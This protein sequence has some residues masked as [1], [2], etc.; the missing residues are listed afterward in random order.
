MNP[1]IIPDH[2]KKSYLKEM[3]EDDFRDKVVRPLFIMKGMRRGKDVCGVDEDGKDCYLYTEDSVRKNI[4]YAIQTKKGDVKMSRVNQDNL[5]NILTQI[6]TALQTPIKDAKNHISVYPD[7]VLLVASGEINKKAQEHIVDEIKDPR[8]QFRDSD[9][10]IPE[11]DAFM[12]EFWLGI[13]AKRLPYLRAFREY[14][15]NQSDTIDMTQIGVA[16]SVAS[17]ITDDTF[18][19]LSLYR[20]SKKVVSSTEGPQD[21]IDVEEFSIPQ[22]LQKPYRLALISGE[23]GSGKTTSLRRLAMM[24]IDQALKSPDDRL[25]PVYIRTL[26]IARAP[27]RLVD[28]AAET[29]MRFTG[30][31]SA[32]FERDDLV[33]GNITLLIDGFDE[34]AAVDQR[35]AFVKKISDFNGEFPKCRIYLTSRES[36]HLKDIEGLKFTRLRISP[37]NLQQAGKIIER[38][39]K[40]KDLPTHTTEEILR[41]LDTVHGI[42]LTPLLVTVFVATTDYARSDIPANITELFKKFTEMMLGRWDQ[43]KGLSQQYQAN[44]KDFLLT[45]IAFEMHKTETTTIKMVDFKQVIEKALQERG[46]SGETA[47]F[48]RRNRQQVRPAPCRK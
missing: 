30:D 1:N 31:H 24:I 43:S 4:L 7:C 18:V 5:L 16:S 14:L 38:I 29:T 35:A 10:L 27:G 9:D 47:I 13:D 22:L 12:P 34:L 46:L 6:R 37:I 11:I 39:S 45:R 17:P 3:S 8:I 15:I 20:Y 28:L 32:A 25:L 2:Q 48:V 42:D 21:A 26:E 19:S 23:A 33:A 44:V 40:G 36:P 41:R